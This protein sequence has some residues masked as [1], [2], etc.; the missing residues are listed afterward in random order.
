M[1]VGAEPHARRSRT[2]GNLYVFGGYRHGRRGETN[3]ALPLRPG[4]TAGRGCPSAP[5]ARAGACARRDRRQAVRG[6]RRAATAGARHARDLRLQDAAVV[7]RA[8]DVARARAPGRR[9][10]RRALL[11]ARG[12]RGRPG[13]LRGRRALRPAPG[14]WEQLPDMEKPRGGIA[15]AVVDGRIVVLRRRGERAARSARSSSTTRPRGAGARCRR[16]ARRGTGWA[17]FR[18]EIACTRSRAGPRRA[19]TSRTRSSSSTYPDAP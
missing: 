12:P 2:S 3:R 5:T 14:R 10:G 1:P 8:V 19:S 18:A 17:A 16:C 6:G 13:Q 7:A 11:R 4:A 15:A 9:R